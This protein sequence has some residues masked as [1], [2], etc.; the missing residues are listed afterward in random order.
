MLRYK[1]NL[2]RIAIHI[3]FWILYLTCLCVL[4]GSYEGKYELEFTIHL[5]LLPVQILVVYFTLYYLIPHLLIKK[6]YIPFFL[7]FFS[8]LFFAGLVQR[9]LGLYFIYPIC[10]AEYVDEDYFKLHRIV[11]SIFN[12]SSVL[13]FASTVKILKYLYQQ[14]QTSKDLENEKLEAELKFL[15]GQIHP[16][17]LFN[18]LNNLYALTLK[19]SDSAPD[20]V[21]KISELMHYMLYDSNTGWVAL[22][23]EIQYIQNYIVLEKMRY[24]KRVEIN[25]NIAGDIRSRQIAPMLIL[26]FVENSFKH[27]V[28]GEIE[29]AW[30]LIDLSLKENQ[31]V[32]KVENSKGFTIPKHSE[33]DYAQGIG[34][35][36]VKRRLEL[37]YAD[38][39]ELKIFDEKDS[40]LIVLKLTLQENKFHEPAQPLN[41][42][43]DEVEMPYRR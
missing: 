2:S 36:N 12:I 13:F 41:T 35:Q 17:F 10:C 11:K 34:L 1:S 8:A 6:Q 3:L 38:Q 32:L 27:G 25:F 28:S 33:K 37:L 22:E 30:I 26:P 16:H 31:M 7:L 20:I 40:Y 23:K 24:G 9:A 43:K 4:W 14:E 5:I 19:K 21:L 18:T 39:Y 29:N 42:N 15:K